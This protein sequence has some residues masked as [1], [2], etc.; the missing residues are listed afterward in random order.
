M[1]ARAYTGGSW[2]DLQK[3]ADEYWRS[4]KGAE[5]GAGRDKV[6]G[7]AMPANVMLQPFS[8]SRCG[9]SSK[10]HFAPLPPNSH[11]PCPPASPHPRPPRQV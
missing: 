10:D 5:R 8:E 6:V 7:R 2:S 11:R 3:S 1:G 9:V 4:T